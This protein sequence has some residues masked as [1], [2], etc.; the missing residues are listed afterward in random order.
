MAVNIIELHI[1][2]R[3]E[4]LTRSVCRVP[5]GNRAGNARKSGCGTASDCASDCSGRN[6]MP[7][8]AGNGVVGIRGTK[9]PTSPQATNVYAAISSS[10]FF[11]LFSRG[12]QDTKNQKN[13]YLCGR[14]IDGS[15]ASVGRCG[16]DAIRLS[17][18]SYARKF[19]ACPSRRA[20]DKVRGDRSADDR[21]RSDCRH[22]EIRRPQQGV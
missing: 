14:V 5:A 13:D 20:E 12:A 10:F 17:P 9:A 21:S 7:P 6:S 18:V 4:V 11:M 19:D 2:I 22:E 15:C 3:A 8:T 16:A 1:V